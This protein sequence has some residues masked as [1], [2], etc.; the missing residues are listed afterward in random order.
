ML[1]RV[2]V[3]VDSSATATAASVVTLVAAV[4]AVL[5]RTGLVSMLMAAVVAGHRAVAAARYTGARLDLALARHHLV[6]QLGRQ[7]ADD[8]VQG[9]DAREPVATHP[10]R[11]GLVDLPHFSLAQ[12]PHHVHHVGRETR[13]AA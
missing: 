4:L 6:V 1:D 11:L 7:Y 8:G 12:H 3:R 10:P 9:L 5:L 2:G 13:H